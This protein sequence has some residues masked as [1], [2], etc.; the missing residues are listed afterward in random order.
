MSR[1][2]LNVTRL[3]VKGPILSAVNAVTIL[4]WCRKNWYPYALKFNLLWA[5]F[6]FFSTTIGE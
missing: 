5:S 1:V 3:S 6:L 2:T 4:L